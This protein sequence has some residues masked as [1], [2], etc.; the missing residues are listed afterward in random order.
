MAAVWRRNWCGRKQPV[1]TLGDA[2]QGSFVIR[3]FG[4]EIEI[5]IHN[6][7]PEHDRKTRDYLALMTRWT[8]PFT[9][10]SFIV[11]ACAVVAGALDLVWLA[12]AAIAAL[13]A[14]VLLVP[15]VRNTAKMDPSSKHRLY[16]WLGDLL[17]PKRA[18]GDLL[19][20]WRTCVLTARILGAVTIV[21]GLL[22]LVGILK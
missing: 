5:P 12:G 3:G 8:Y 9:A 19:V 22:V 10:A 18:P 7:S 11:M 4:L 14:L 15:A 17:M 2:I 6:C 16:R 1:E 13:G 21:L 20:P